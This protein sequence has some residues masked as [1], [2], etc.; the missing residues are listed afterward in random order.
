[1]IKVKRRINTEYNVPQG[2]ATMNV[3]TE[4]SVWEWINLLVPAN[5]RYLKHFVEQSWE[6]DEDAI[7]YKPNFS[8]I[9]IPL[10]RIHFDLI[11]Y[12]EEH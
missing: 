10:G 8:D 7:V 4:S 1:M 2:Y 6:C 9:E 11:V 3:P 5:G 12:Y